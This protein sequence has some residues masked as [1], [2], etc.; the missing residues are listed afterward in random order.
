MNVL[1]DDFFGRCGICG[2]VFTPETDGEG[3]IY[4]SANHG[5]ICEDCR[6]KFDFQAVA[7]RAEKYY[8]LTER[9]REDLSGEHDEQL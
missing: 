8:S 5:A 7:D 6:E 3:L 1:D 2:K 9:R 4:Q